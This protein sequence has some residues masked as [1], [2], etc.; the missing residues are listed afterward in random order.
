MAVTVSALP[1]VQQ[2]FLQC[3]PHLG[4]VQ[5]TVENAVGARLKGFA[6]SRIF[7]G[8]GQDY[9]FLR[10]RQQRYQS[11]EFS[12]FGQHEVRDHERALSSQREFENLLLGAAE[13]VVDSG[14]V[15]DG[16]QNS[17]GRG[18]VAEH[19]SE[20]RPAL[21][22]EPGHALK[23]RRRRGGVNVTPV[24]RK[25]VTEAWILKRFLG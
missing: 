7:F 11:H 1:A 17:K 24:I 13:E 16:P 6:G 19:S 2:N 10:R 12:C 4:A 20:T 15:E 25:R 18:M 21:R 22:H 5:W 9:R 8:H 3:V 14:F 23:L